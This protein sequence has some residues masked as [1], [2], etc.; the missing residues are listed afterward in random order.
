[1]LL[2]PPLQGLLLKPPLLSKRSES[3]FD[4][5]GWSH[6]FMSGSI[7]SNITASRSS[8]ASYT[9]GS[10]TRSYAGDNIL[11]PD[12]NKQTGQFRGLLTEGNRTNYLLNSESPANQTT[13]SLSTGTYTLWIEGPGSVAV[14]AGTATATGLGTA[15]E[16]SPVTFTV[17][18]A[19]TVS[20]AITGTV[21]AF[22]IENGG[23]KSQ[24]IRTVGSTATRQVDSCS[25]NNLQ[26]IGLSDF[27]SG[28]IYM[29]LEF[30]GLPAASTFPRLFSLSNNAA[31]ARL[32]VYMNR[33]NSRISASG[34]GSDF[35]SGVNYA[36]GSIFRV[37]LGWSPTKMGISVNGNADVEA[38]VSN[39][40]TDLTKLD[41]NYNYF[42]TYCFKWIR[43]LGVLPYYNP[44]T[45]RNLS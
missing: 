21:T 40:P 37:A 43:F 42:N 2:N 15:T 31:N 14:S 45:L 11:R 39:M 28:T 9:N 35:S 25:I 36:L 29:E 13:G 1:M 5:G 41:L 26:S 10:L 12:F 4:A 34:G 8:E 3:F 33:S 16:S 17:T 44:G 32:D 30:E 7:P 23:F 27:S 38:A 22:Q 6:D 24:L 20:V 19:G 18:V